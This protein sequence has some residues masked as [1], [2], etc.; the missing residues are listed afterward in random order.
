MTTSITETGP[1]ERLVKF[2]I[3]EDAISEAKKTA[4]RRLAE[5]IK[6]PG[7]RPAR[8]RSRSSRPPSV[9]IGSARRRSTRHSLV[10]T[11]ILREEELQPAVTRASSR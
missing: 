7:F 8:P 10:L 2:H 1:F 5:G 11:E 4:A 9:P 3:A 6:I